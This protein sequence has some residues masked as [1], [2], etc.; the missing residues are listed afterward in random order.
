MSKIR[1][2]CHDNSNPSGGI[3]TLYRQVDILLSHGYDVAVMH[4]KADFRLQWFEHTTPT[5]GLHRN[6]ESD[7]WIVFP[8]DY[9]DMMQFFA[10]VSCNKVVFCQKFLC[11][12]GA[13][14][15]VSIL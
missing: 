4:E 12:C 1:F 7:D 10:D 5:E 9:I 8:E 13:I 2:V 11:L 15:Y 3:R 14:I 6:F